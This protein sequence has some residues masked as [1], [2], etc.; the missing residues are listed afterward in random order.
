MRALA[1]AILFQLAAFGVAFAQAPPGAPPSLSCGVP[2][3]GAT[4]IGSFIGKTVNAAFYT[5]GSSGGSDAISLTPISTTRDPN[6]ILSVAV[7]DAKLKPL[8]SRGQNSVFGLEFDVTDPGDYLVVV[9]A[10][11]NNPGTFH[12]ILQRLNQPCAATPRLDCGVLAKTALQPLA[13]VQ[14]FQFTANQN[15][16]ITLRMAKNGGD[17]RTVAGLAVYDARGQLENA[18]TSSISLRLNLKLATSGT[19]SVFV[20]DAPNSP[21]T[22][23]ALTLTKPGGQCNATATGC[24]AA[25]DASIGEPGKVG[26]YSIDANAGDVFLLRI[27]RTEGSSGFVPFLELYDPQG[28]FLQSARGPALQRFTFTASSAGTYSAQVTDAFDGTRTGSYSLSLTRLNSPCNGVSLGCGTLANGSIDGPLRFTTYS[29]FANTGESFSVRLIDNSGSLQPGLEI[30]DPQGNAVGAPIGVGSQ[31]LDVTLPVGGFYT[32]LATDKATNRGPFEVELF[33]TKNACSTG[34]PPQGQSIAGAVSGAAPFTAYTVQAAAGDS[35]LLRASNSGAGFN[36]NVEVYNPDGVRLNPAP[37]SAIPV[38]V[39]GSHTV[40]LGAAAVRTTG[41][42]VFSWQLA[43][44]PA[45]T[46]PLACGRTLEDFLTPV[47]QFRYYTANANAGDLLRVLLTR[48]SDGFGPKMELYTPAGAQIGG[49]V[50]EVNAPAAVAGDYL[51]AV[52]PSTASAESGNFGLVF[53]RPNNPCSPIA[54]ACGQTVL[55]S[56]D[57]PGQLDAFQFQANAG[58][59]I[60]LRTPNRLGSF[61]PFLDL[62]D[63]SGRRIDGGPTTILT[64][65]IGTSGLYSL[66]VHD[67]F[68]PGAGTYRVSLQRADNSCAMKDTENPVIRLLRPT[69]GEVIPGGSAYRIAWQSDDN[70]DVVSHEVRLSLDSGQTFP[71]LL[72]GSLSGANQVFDWQVASSVAPTRTAK[73]QVTARD[74]AGNSATATS[75]LLALIGSGFPENSNVTYEYDGLNRIVKAT[76]KTGKVVLY[77]YDAAGNLVQ[78]T[79]Q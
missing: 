78:I 13:S 6:F 20:F 55:R 53:Q 24:A 9:S 5:Y 35:L 14:A 11:G 1:G 10:S 33:R 40:I 68:G 43:N 28:T 47:S 31:A 25:L 41:S 54:L 7:Y 30:Y 3:D 34:S 42:Y 72:S 12:L 75:D 26:L 59:Q 18:Q 61:S 70:V 36:A 58:D 23:F 51:I 2:V 73:I 48:A 62:Y 50:T 49:R 4:A 38:T 63:S 56:V 65:T 71:T 37:F 46:L 79:E 60:T 32:I 44:R 77:T 39:S 64:E 15:D 57:L 8:A 52:G 27:I 22:S 29:Y 45:G 21:S 16:L 69:G 67:R 76:Y 19:H 74:A 66:F 17:A